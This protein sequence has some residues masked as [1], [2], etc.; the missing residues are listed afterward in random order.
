MPNRPALKTIAQM[1][2]L[3]HMA[4]SKAPR[5]VPSTSAAKE[6]AR[7][8]VSKAGCTFS[9]CFHK[10]GKRMPRGLRRQKIK[11]RRESL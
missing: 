3:S 8:I 9:L 2:G 1:V 10:I 5:D 7:K 6:R 11:I 4:A